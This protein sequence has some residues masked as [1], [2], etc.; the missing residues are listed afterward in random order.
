MKLIRSNYY[1]NC[2]IAVDDAERCLIIY[3]K[4]IL[5]LKA[6]AVRDKPKILGVMKSTQIP[7]EIRGHHQIEVL[8]L[9]YYFVQR[10][11]HFYCIGITYESRI[12]D[13]VVVKSKSKNYDI[14]KS[15]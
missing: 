14:I 5:N 7:Q 12:I 15:I 1:R 9:D 13:H 10:L 4:G 3:G 11:P 2:P 8:S 6:S